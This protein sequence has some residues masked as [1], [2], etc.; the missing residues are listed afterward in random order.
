MSLYN[1]QHESRSSVEHQQQFQQ[2]Q[3]YLQREAAARLTS[4]TS[5]HAHAASSPPPGGGAVHHECHTLNC[6]SRGHWGLHTPHNHIGVRPGLSLD[7]DEHSDADMQSFPVDYLPDRSALSCM[8]RT[9]QRQLSTGR[10]VGPSHA[11]CANCGSG[12]ALPSHH[13][14]R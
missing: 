12:Q 2:H 13:S 9:A 3:Q 4:C 5:G 10:M 1:S 14:H 8:A 11:H 6:P 7:E